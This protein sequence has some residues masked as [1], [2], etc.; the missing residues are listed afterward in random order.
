MV[1]VYFENGNLILY[2]NK[3]VN[4]G[5]NRVWNSLYLN[6][7][8]WVFFWIIVFKISIKDCW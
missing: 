6:F 2:I 1:C 4:L 3:V 7:F 5:F 8:G